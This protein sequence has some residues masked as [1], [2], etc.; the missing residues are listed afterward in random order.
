MSVLETLLND[1]RNRSERLLERAGELEAEARQSS[2]VR[3]FADS[4]RSAAPLLAIVAEFKRRSPSKGVLGEHLDLVEQVTSYSEGGASAL[5][6]LTEPT[7][8]GG[9]LE[10]MQRARAATNL[11]VLR[12]DF[13]VSDVQIYE[14][15]AAGA[16]A[17]LLICSGFREQRDLRALVHTARSLELDVLLEVHSAAEARSVADIEEV[18]FGVNARDLST[19]E[20]HLDRALA[21]RALFPS[22]ACVLAESAI[23]S[24]EDAVRAHEAGFSGVLVGEYFMRSAH[25]IASVHELATIGISDEQTIKRS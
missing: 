7:G 11:P 5:S 3:G 13:I 1:A 21:I 6:I 20:E 12:K 15:R 9:S 16:D 4:I 8:F 22:D 23:R 18:V 2:P 10:D 25:T 19:F 14:A 24:R 17:I